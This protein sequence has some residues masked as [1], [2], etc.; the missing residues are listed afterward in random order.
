MSVSAPHVDSRVPPLREG[1]VSSL[2][3]GGASGI[4]GDLCGTVGYEEA[5]FVVRSLVSQKRASTRQ[6]GHS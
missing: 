5:P 4:P 2:P 1:V 6:Y 3:N